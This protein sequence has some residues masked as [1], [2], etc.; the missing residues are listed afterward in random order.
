MNM[1]C[2]N[3]PQ[4]YPERAD[5]VANKKGDLL[6]HFHVADAD[7]DR[8]L[9]DKRVKAVTKQLWK[10]DLSF[11]DMLSRLG[12]DFSSAWRGSPQSGMKDYTR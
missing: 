2:N 9:S 1:K 12:S 8:F 5:Y 11:D 3:Y 10:E 4:D 6:A 7:T